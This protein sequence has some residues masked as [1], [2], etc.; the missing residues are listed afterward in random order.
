MA[1]KPRWFTT[2]FRANQETH[3]Y[4]KEQARRSG[5]S[6]TQAAGVI[7]DEARRQGW[8]IGPVIV[9]RHPAEVVRE[10]QDALSCYMV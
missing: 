2:Q 4:L 8:Q 10:Q 9:T 1:D 6:V 5:I 3:E 7:L